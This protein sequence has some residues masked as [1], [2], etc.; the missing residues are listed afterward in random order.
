MVLKVGVMVI[1]VY[2]LI[3]YIKNTE[4]IKSND[5]FYQPSYSFKKIEKIKIKYLLMCMSYE[6]L[7]NIK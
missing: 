2:L 7:N 6:L 1:P 4:F 3:R 5:S